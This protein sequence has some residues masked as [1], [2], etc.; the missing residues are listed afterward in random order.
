MSDLGV[1]YA[2]LAAGCGALFL[3]AVWLA[4]RLPRT[5]IDL[6]AVV[7]VAGLIAYIRYLWYQPAL[8]QWLPYSNLIVI[9]NWLP[10]FSAIIAGLVWQRTAA[11]PARRPLLL[12]GLGFCG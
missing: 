4:R 5:G 12:L 6:A 1:G 2:V 9:G 7:A 10:L 11:T 3:A 8:A